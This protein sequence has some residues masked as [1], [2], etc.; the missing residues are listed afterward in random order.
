MPANRSSQ[1]ATTHARI[2]IRGSRRIVKLTRVTAKIGAELRTLQFTFEGGRRRGSRCKTS[3]LDPSNVPDF[4]GDEAW[5]EVEEYRGQP[6]SYWV[7]LQRVEEPPAPP[8]RP[9]V[10]RTR[11]ITNTDRVL[12]D[13]RPDD[14][15]VRDCQVAWFTVTVWCDG[16]RCRPR[17]LS[18]LEMGGWAEHKIIDLVNDGRCVCQACGGTAQ[19]VSISSPERQGRI[20]FWRRG[21]GHLPHA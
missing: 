4:T 13:T 20:L 9:A 7:A 11:A 21:V 15:T 12:A 17:N 6:W 8:E 3:F 1:S 2:P 10:P 18:L 14:L 5:F 19:V 16:R